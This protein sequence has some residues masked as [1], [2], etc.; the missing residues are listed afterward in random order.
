MLCWA[1][2]SRSSPGIGPPLVSVKHQLLLS[3]AYVGLLGHSFPQYQAD[4]SPIVCV[5]L[6]LDSWNYCSG[7]QAQQPNNFFSM[8]A[9]HHFI[10]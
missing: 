5:V 6:A 10:D 9:M 1:S 7:E 4:S 8:F 3:L 2:V